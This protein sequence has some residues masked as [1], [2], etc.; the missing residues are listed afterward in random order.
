[1]EFSG[2]RL[3]ISNRA[4]LLMLRINDAVDRDGAKTRAR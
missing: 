2:G 3:V 4:G 1:M